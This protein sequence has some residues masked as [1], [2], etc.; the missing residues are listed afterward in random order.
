MRE[1][2]LNGDKRRILLEKFFAVKT[3]TLRHERLV[4]QF[5][6]NVVEEESHKLGRNKLSPYKAVLFHVISSIELQPKL[7]LGLL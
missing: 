4:S 2:R 3:R 6:V 7:P 5:R 1:V